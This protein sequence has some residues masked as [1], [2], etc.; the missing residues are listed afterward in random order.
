M[1]II[2]LSI[3]VLN[4]EVHRSPGVIS[5]SRGYFVDN[6]LTSFVDNMLI[7]LVDNMLTSFV[8][9]MLTSIVECG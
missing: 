8:D 2:N 9:N 4:Y 1:Y 7:S 6:M 3:S 5:A